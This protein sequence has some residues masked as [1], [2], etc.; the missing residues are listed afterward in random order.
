M[1]KETQ[2]SIRFRASRFFSDRQAY[3]AEPH[4]IS[5]LVAFGIVLFMALWP[6]ISLVHTMAASR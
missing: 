1:K 6:I 3:N 4:Y 2:S 5:E